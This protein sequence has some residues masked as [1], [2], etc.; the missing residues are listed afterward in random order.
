M[1]ITQARGRVHVGPQRLPTIPAVHPS[2]ALRAR[3]D[4]DRYAARAAFQD[5]LAAVA[6]VVEDGLAPLLESSTKAELGELL[7]GPLGITGWRGT[8]K[9]ELVLQLVAAFD[10]ASTTTDASSTTGASSH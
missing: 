1:K 9:A 7:A 4:E 10:T 3:S 5:D 6:T 8:R 2:S